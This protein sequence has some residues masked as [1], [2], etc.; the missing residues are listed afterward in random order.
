M[1]ENVLLASGAHAPR[2]FNF[3]SD[4]VRVVMKDGQA[5]FVA[6][7]VAEAVGNR[8]AGTAS[9][10]H[11]PEM[12]RGVNSVL[13][14]SGYQEM[15]TLSEQGVYFFLGRSDKPKA[16]PFQMWL[17]GDV[18]PA[19]RKHG[20]YATEDLLDNPDLLI[21]MATRL[22]E[23]K[24]Q[25]RMAEL[26][27]M[28]LEETVLEMGPKAAYVDEVLK[29]ENGITISTIAKA[30]GF[31]SARELN[32][33]LHHL[34][35]QYQQGKQWVLYAPYCGEGYTVEQTLVCTG[36]NG[37]TRTTHHTKW[38]ERGKKFLRQLL[39]EHGYKIRR[40]DQGAC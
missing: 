6:K 22:K 9:I 3:G 14:P 25:R 31:A 7:D 37:A 1:I 38:T 24:E 11:V 33:V 17:A 23:E 8:W 20:L 26:K 35:V 15:A 39:I 5:Q 30:F 16:L 40:E 32:L 21:A 10:R 27:A 2:V 36:S 29:A 4:E 28:Q 18:V 34:G 12:W 13:T 19:I